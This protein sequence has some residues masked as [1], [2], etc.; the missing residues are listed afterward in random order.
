MPAARRTSRRTSPVTITHTTPTRAPSP[1]ENRA[2]PLDMMP[3]YHR[4]GVMTLT[5]ARTLYRGGVLP[6]DVGD[7]TRVGVGLADYTRMAYLASHHITPDMLTDYPT[8]TYDYH[9]AALI[10]AGVSADTAHAYGHALGWCCG[11]QHATTRLY[12]QWGFVPG[13][14]TSG[15]DPLHI[16]DLVSHGAHTPYLICEMLALRASARL[17]TFTKPGDIRPVWK[18]WVAAADGHVAV[19]RA[20]CDAGGTLDTVTAWL[21]TGQAPDRIAVLARTGVD[22]ATVQTRPLSDLTDDDLE[23]WA[24][25]NEL[26]AR[27][28]IAS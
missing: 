17:L 28:A 25:L 10:H 6:D 12:P 26:A 9:L 8:I 19:A 13:W 14:A 16:A 27:D 11:Q 2:L 7:W 23:V 15:A 5:H 1:R 21:Q 20:V 24:I 18:T 4:V 22:P 3:D